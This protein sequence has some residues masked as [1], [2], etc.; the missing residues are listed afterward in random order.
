MGH[1]K[2]YFQAFDTTDG[3]FPFN[4]IY[5]NSLT[6]IYNKDFNFKSDEDYNILRLFPF[7]RWFPVHATL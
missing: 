2:Q 7:V 5:G 1:H 6:D 4:N 3:L